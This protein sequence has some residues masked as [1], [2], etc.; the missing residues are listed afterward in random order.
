MSSHFSHKA[1]AME[2]D[3]SFAAGKPPR[4]LLV[5]MPPDYQPEYLPL[6]LGQHHIAASIENEGIFEKFIRRGGLIRTCL[7]A[8]CEDLASVF[9]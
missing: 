2:L 6:S 7:Q 3:G 9:Q 4:Y 5:C 1:V 8:V